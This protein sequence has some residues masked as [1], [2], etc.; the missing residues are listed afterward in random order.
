MFGSKKW[1]WIQGCSGEDLSLN[2]HTVVIFIVR[3]GGRLRL[4]CG[5]DLN[6]RLLSGDARAQLSFE[7]HGGDVVLRLFSGGWFPLSNLDVM[8]IYFLF[9]THPQTSVMRNDKERGNDKE[10]GKG[11]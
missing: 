11:K 9:P 1:R 10:S 6:Q 3:L 2:D 4:L 5:G 7:N 8:P